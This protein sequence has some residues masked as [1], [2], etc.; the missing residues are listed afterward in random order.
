MY[1]GTAVEINV[2]IHLSLLQFQS[3]ALLPAW[4]GMEALW[5][6]FSNSSLFGHLLHITL[7]WHQMWGES[8]LNASEF[9]REEGEAWGGGDIC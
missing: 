1:R 8:G 4:K 7:A 5:E 2:G 6:R 9:W 3:T